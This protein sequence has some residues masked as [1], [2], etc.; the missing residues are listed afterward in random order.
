MGRHWMT[1][2]GGIAL[3]AMLAATAAGCATLPGSAS[4]ATQPAQSGSASPQHMT[5]R[6]D[7]AS[8]RPLAWDSWRQ[9]TP[10]SIEISFLAG[11]ASC[12]GIHVAVT[13]TA[14]DV[15]IDLT[16]GPLPGVGQCQAIALT[17]T[18]TITLAQP[19]DGRPVHHTT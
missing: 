2:F 19:L 6:E 17:T 1:V 9:L 3:M 4:S 12:E 16:A 8:Q 14:R 10:T 13:E 11:P 18:T 15:T 5:S 7:L